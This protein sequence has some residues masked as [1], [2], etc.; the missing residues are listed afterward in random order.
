[1]EDNGW[2][3]RVGEE[4]NRENNNGVSVQKLSQ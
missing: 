2:E 1:M 4:M 3:R